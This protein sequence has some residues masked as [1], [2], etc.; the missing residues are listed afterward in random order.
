M[1]KN[2]YNYLKPFV[3]DTK[4]EEERQYLFKRKLHVKS[5]EN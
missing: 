3:Q 5:G 4:G 2:R 1:T